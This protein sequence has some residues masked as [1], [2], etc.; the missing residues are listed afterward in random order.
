L[1]VNDLKRHLKELEKA[2]VVAFGGVGFAGEVLPV[3]RAYDAI[4]GEL[5]EAVR[6]GLERLL[7]RATP[8]GKVYAATLLTRL[9]PDAGRAAWRRLAG[10]RSPV[11]TFS[12]CV[13]GRTTLAAYASA[14]PGA[15]G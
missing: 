7:D 10:D 12:G 13:R 6:P 1:P 4:A 2:D 15:P 11:A 14:Q 9:D 3:T 8:A 5:T